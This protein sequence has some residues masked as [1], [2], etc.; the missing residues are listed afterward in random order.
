VD[1]IIDTVKYSR[2]LG[3]KLKSFRENCPVFFDLV[4]SNTEVTIINHRD[5]YREKT[6]QIQFRKSVKDNIKVIRDYLVDFF[7]YIYEQ[8]LQRPSSG[9][10]RTLIQRGE[11]IEKAIEHREKV[12]IKKYRVEKVSNKYNEVQTLD[13]ISEVKTIWKLKTPVMFFMNEVYKDNYLTESFYIKAN[14][15]KD[16]Y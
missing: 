5:H 14:K 13:L 2:E 7:P 6:F 15:Y 12:L 11:P 16:L 1:Q 4:V 10:V 3:Q 9:Q 8:S